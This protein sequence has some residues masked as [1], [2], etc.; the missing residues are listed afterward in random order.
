[1][2][3]AIDWAPTSHQL[4]D[5]QGSENG[6]YFSHFKENRNSAR[7]HGAPKMIFE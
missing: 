2:K 3:P 4:F 7:S 6:Y 5:S 1:M